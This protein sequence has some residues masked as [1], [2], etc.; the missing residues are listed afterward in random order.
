MLLQA[1]AAAGQR[2]DHGAVVL[3]EG[4]TAFVEEPV[5]AT[6]FHR[7][8]YLALALFAFA[9][10]APARALG[11]A[12]SVG[13]APPA[14]P[15]YVQPACPGPGYLWTPGYWAY[16]PVYGYYWVPGT[17]VP[18]PV[19]LLW[20][21]GYWGFAEGLYVWHAGYWG[22]RVG[23]YGG[24]NYGFGYFGAGFAGGYWRDHAFYYNRAVTNVT[25]T[26]IT[27]VYNTPVVNNV[28]G[29]HA[30]FNGPGGVQA[31]PTAPELEAANDRHFGATSDQQRHESQARALPSLRASANR[32]QPPIA[33]ASR[34]G[35]FG[36]HGGGLAQRGE[37]Q[38][39]H[40]AAHAPRNGA[41]APH[42]PAPG[43]HASG[44]AYP[45]HTA[46]SGGEAARARAPYGARAPVAR[47]V[48]RWSPPARPMQV[49]YSSAPAARVAS[50]RTAREPAARRD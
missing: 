21:P 44:Q 1:G 16:D 13:F 28:G 22:P 29:S 49:H 26:S 48:A 40:G 39:P 23:F 3:S 31:R 4:T 47:P 5:K 10:A 8:L 25:N 46:Y 37:G 7:A 32:G 24:V 30:S 38:A 19:G 50:P 20:T 2:P 12:V 6:N 34:P 17:W 45:G 9:I 43:N 27:N 15:V 36:A 18:A 35:A 41:N 14:L 11:V 33:A 42:R